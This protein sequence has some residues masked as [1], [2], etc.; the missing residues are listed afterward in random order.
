MK[1]TLIAKED[2]LN[3]MTREYINLLTMDCK[4]FQKRVGRA[5]IGSFG[6]PI[7]TN[8][9]FLFTSTEKELDPSPYYA[10]YASL[11]KLETY[12]AMYD[13]LSQKEEE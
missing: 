3:A 2:C 12:A 8:I 11:T 1:K 13:L 10:K 6:K 9:I 4:S 5:L 7:N